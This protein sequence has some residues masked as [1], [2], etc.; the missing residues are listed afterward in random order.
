MKKF[1]LVSLS[2]LALHLPALAADEK[3]VPDMTRNDC[4]EMNAALRA[5]DGYDYVSNAGKEERVVRRAYKMGDSRSAV[6]LNL[7]ALKPFVEAFN[8]AQQALVAEIGNGDS[9]NQFK[10][11]QKGEPDPLLGETEEWKSY[12]KRYE[13]L[14]KEPCNVVLSRLKQSDFKANDDNPIPGSILSVILKITD[15]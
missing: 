6:A 4:M 5:L 7:T 3:P 9:I 1:L 14:T 11:N 12:A 15:K 13:A 8:A 10:K 2:V